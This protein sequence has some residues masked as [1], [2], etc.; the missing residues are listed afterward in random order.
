[1][2]NDV[3]Y[4]IFLLSALFR[5]HQNRFYLIVEDVD[6]AEE[7]GQVEPQVEEVVSMIEAALVRKDI[8]SP[9]LQSF[10]V[11]LLTSGVVEEV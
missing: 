5:G 3:P 2:I 8:I 7:G 6:D 11:H 9:G 10:H 4:N 1:M